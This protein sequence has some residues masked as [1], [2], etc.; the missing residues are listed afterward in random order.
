[1]VTTQK[2]RG[3]VL[4]FLRNKR[5][6]KVHVDEEF[7]T[8]PH[9]GTTGPR[10]SSNA[11]LIQHT[12]TLHWE[13]VSYEIP[14]KKGKHKE[15]LQNI[16][17]WVKPGTL[18]ALMGATG[19]GKTSLLDVIAQ[20]TT[21]GSITG[22]I[23][24]D[25]Q[26][27]NAS[28]QRST[29]YAQQNDIHLRSATVREALQ[30]SAVLRQQQNISKASKLSY[31]ESIIDLLGMQAYAD[32]VIGVPG[33]GLSPEQ[34]KRLTIA[35]ELAGRPTA[36]LFLDEPTSGLDSQTAFSICNL[37]RDLAHNSGQAI[38]CTIH[39]PSATLLGLFDN[40]LLMEKGK[41]IYFG[42]VGSGVKTITQY[43]ESK[44][45][46]PCQQGE[47]PA[48]WVM[49]VTGAS[50]GS[51][52]TIDW[53]NTW[54]YSSERQLVK[55]HLAQIKETAIKHSAIGSTAN[56]YATPMWKQLAVLT[57]RTFVE[58]W[59]TPEAVW[60]KLLLYATAS[61]VIGVSCFRSPNSLQGLQNQMFSIFLL[62]TTFSNV[63]QQIAPQF[64]NRRALFEARERP[65]KIFSWIAFVSASIIVEA[66]WQVLLATISW[67]LFYYLTGMNLNATGSDQHERAALMLLFFIA[68][69]LFTQALAHLLVAAIEVPETAINMGQ[70]IFY[71]TII[72]CG[73]LVPKSS[74]PHFWI[75]MYRMSPLTYL[76]RGM[77]AVG[78]SGQPITCSSAELVRMPQPPD[79][80]TCGDFLRE[81]VNLTGGLVVN[82]DFKGTC[83]YCPMASTDQFLDYFS[84]K[85]SERWRDLG[86]IVVF[87]V[88]NWAAT[89]ALY[90]VARVP[91]KPKI[92]QGTTGG[93]K[94]TV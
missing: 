63:L 77:F 47:N 54:K 30:F 72:F 50:P 89:V 22:D 52:N 49:D 13:N 81:F 33:N 25:G 40:L 87:V 79:N 5:P 74:L 67:A 38:M 73:V 16:D 90:W 80:R 27:R 82:P 19:A 60:S 53:S 46:R 75:F 71:L 45:A 8:R 59:R 36:T 69:F 86:I 48:E 84:M 3:D 17:G 21:Q 43:F 9:Q 2:P 23:L 41:P 83:E 66:A 62:F 35:V 34:R 88:F 14:L 24:V 32:A 78:V 44:G 18:T 20:R 15:V 61:F 68:F 91:K 65:S 12:S 93:E 11:T 55:Q 26:P 70:P 29:G 10:I 7:H 4:L 92:M 28:F 76:M 31:V 94:T 51:N 37:L 42:G 57:H 56:A 85:Y 64:T 6:P 39:Q 58:Y 1:M